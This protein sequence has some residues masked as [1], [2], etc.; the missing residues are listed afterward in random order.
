MEPELPYEMLFKRDDLQYFTIS[1]QDNGNTGVEICGQN[2]YI[3]FHSG[4]GGSGSDY[5]Q[6]LISSRSGNLLAYPGIS[7]SSDRRLKHDIEDLD[8]SLA[9][10]LLS[11]KPKSFVYDRIPDRTRLGFVAQD[12]IKSME[13]NGFSKDEMS[14][15]DTFIDENGVEMYAVDYTQFIAPL[16]YG[17][18]SLLERVKVLEKN[19]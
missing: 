6:R 18:Q 12:V 10:T 5:T 13:D 19:N 11:V 2:S 1:L 8:N 17:Y 15:I 4:E 16:V 3:D 7:N 9:D 14:I